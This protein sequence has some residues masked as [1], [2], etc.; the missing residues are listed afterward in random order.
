LDRVLIPLEP[1]SLCT[2]DNVSDFDLASP[3]WVVEPHA[4]KKNLPLFSVI[5]RSGS[6]RYWFGPFKQHEIEPF[7]ESRR[8]IFERMSRLR[9]IAKN[10]ARPEFAAGARLSNVLQAAG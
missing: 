5:E 9:S 2:E 3:V 8:T 7:I 1:E 6:S 4:R 10:Q